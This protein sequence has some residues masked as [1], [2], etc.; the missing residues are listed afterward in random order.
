ML[1]SNDPGAVALFFALSSLPLPVIVFPADARAWRSSPPV[2]AG[3]PLFLPPSLH[4]MA[5][6]GDSLG[7]RTF[8]LPDPQPRSLAAGAVPLW[9]EP[10]AYRAARGASDL[11]PESCTGSGGNEQREGAAAVVSLHNMVGE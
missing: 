4:A 11:I 10:R 9:A 2:P 1:M 5:A 3:T 7:L 6:A 8:V